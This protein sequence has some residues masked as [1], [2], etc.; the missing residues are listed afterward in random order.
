[1]WSGG[2]EKVG[3]KHGYTIRSYRL[4]GI[5]VGGDF[6]Y[7]VLISL[8]FGETDMVI[9]V[10]GPRWKA[11]GVILALR[12]SIYFFTLIQVNLLEYYFVI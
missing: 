12:A 4:V 3:F 2:V 6:K 8:L 5:F 1:M 11:R 10:A 7:F 9:V